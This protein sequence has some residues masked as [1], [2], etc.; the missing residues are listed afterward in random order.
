M[1]ATSY[2]SLITRAN[3]I[4]TAIGG[5]SVTPSNVGGLIRDLID[6]VSVVTASGMRPSSTAA[7]NRA[8]L[9]AVL[10]SAT[11]GTLIT[12]P[13]GSYPLDASNASPIVV[14]DGVYL[15]G[16][17][18]R[19]TTL[20][21]SGKS[22]YNYDAGMIRYVGSGRSNVVTVSTTVPLGSLYAVC[23]SVA[24]F[25]S[26]DIVQ[27]R[28]TES[29][30][31]SD[32]GTRAEFLR[33][34]YVDTGASRVYFTTPTQEVYNTGLGTVQLAKVTLATGGISDLT[35]K[36]KGSNPLGWPTP[37][38]YTSTA[39]INDSAQNTRSDYG[40]ECIWARDVTVQRVRFVDVE[41]QA[42]SFRASYGWTVTDCVFEFSAI[43]ERSQYAVFAYSSA[44]EGR[45]TDNF[46]I[47][48]RHFFTT[49]STSATGTDWYF[50]VPHNITVKGN[51]VLGSW[52]SGIDCHRAGHSIVIDGNVVQGY[53]AGIKTRASRV[54]I[55]NNICIGPNATEAQGSYDGIQVQ[56]GCTD[57]IVKGNKI[58]GHACG[59][60]VSSPDA[61]FANLSIEGN[62]INGCGAYGV[63]VSTDAFTGRRV[64][65][66]GN[67]IETP[68]FYGVF[69][70]G[71]FE[72]SS[73]DRNTINGGT[74]GIRTPATGTRTG[75]SVQGNVI[76]GTTNDPIYLE[77]CNSVTVSGNQLFGANTNGVHLRM[78]DCKRGSVIGNHIT[79]PSGA[80]GGT[81]IYLN[82]T[83]S[84]TCSDLMV[85][86]NEVYSASSV[87]TGISFDSQA[88]Q[89]HT[90]G[91]TNNCRTCAT[92]VS[93]SAGDPTIRNRVATQS[94]TIA[95][96]AITACNGAPLVI[97]DTEGAAATDNLA[98]ISYSGRT[99]DIVTFR[100]NSDA[101]DVTFK[102][103]TGN[104]RL[105]GDCVLTVGNDSITLQWR[106]TTWSEIARSING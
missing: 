6:S 30:V 99:G 5:N 50:G 1:T 27:I 34:R 68:T 3:S 51:V 83:G 36:G 11:S 86:G 69:P 101:R 81:G 77:L 82:C 46:C 67:I 88:S 58:Y 16:A 91:D 54:V 42:V 74:Y 73:F 44:S 72:D 12:I 80:S 35:I 32:G 7:Q 53:Y 92:E 4:R 18:M 40:V 9:D 84:G 22:T 41:N 26:G 13:Q 33:V 20:D 71:N 87:G 93:S 38:Q 76:R 21:F 100:Q 14:P 78:R 28:S 62:I 59:V 29:Y 39:E 52:Q 102:D 96:D 25:A 48:C 95:S 43:Q 10:A 24:G 23:S 103:G 17:G 19:L 31:V 85:D 79:I 47:N 8:A 61:D 104:L 57:V 94:V 90:V 89:Y 2:D 49:G 70:D 75:I 37:D 97:V 63:R 105:A 56:Y 15:R 64:R 45:V 106:G 98:T 66:E 65:V 55:S 60:R